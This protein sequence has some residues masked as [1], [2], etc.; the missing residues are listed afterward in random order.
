MLINAFRRALSR[1][2]AEAA[3]ACNNLPPRPPPLC[4][5]TI[6]RRQGVLSTRP[7]H[8]STARAR[9]VHSPEN[10]NVEHSEWLTDSSGFGKEAKAGNHLDS[11]DLEQIA[12]GK[13]KLSPTSSHLFKL[14]LPLESL[15]DQLGLSKKTSA[16]AS[17]PVP[18]VFLLHPAQPLSHVSRLLSASLPDHSCDITIRSHTRSGETQQWSDSTDLADFVREAA[19]TNSFVV[20]IVRTR[21]NGEEDI[22]ELPVEVPTFA[23]RTRYLRLRLQRISKEIKKMESLKK[24]CDHEAHKGAKRFALGG[25]GML[26][27]YWGLVARLT[28]WDFGWDIMEP[29]T[30]LSGLST[31]ILG[32][33]WFL[34][35]GREVSYTSVLDS[36][37]HNRRNALY[38][39]RGFDIERWNELLSEE[40]MIRREISDIAR[41]YDNSQ[42]D[43]KA[44]DQDDEESANERK[45]PR[46]EDLKE[47]DRAMM[48]ASKETEEKK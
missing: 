29:V 45:T 10:V 42:K 8:S 1:P 48:K 21:D 7:L 23:D 25:L 27:S 20:R 9:S 2:H 33:L 40:R 41:D 36:S 18:T 39:S 19:R 28:F 44:I 38:E 3:F 14:I 17:T 6:L 46:V 12:E 24:A 31:V 34:Y 15:I 35:R 5:H 11:D 26:V 4:I 47:E 43:R 32:Y 13:G 16:K 22:H 30:Y 37:I